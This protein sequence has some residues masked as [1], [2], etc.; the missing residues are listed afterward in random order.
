MVMGTGP[1]NPIASL[2]LLQLL[3]R[4]MTSGPIPPVAN[5]R[6]N[7]VI[8]N[9]TTRIHRRD[10]HF[11]SRMAAQRLALPVVGRSGVYQRRKELPLSCWLGGTSKQ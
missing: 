11:G 2:N 9:A 4:K 7:C 8:P 3:P 10:R 5:P 1:Q 6:C